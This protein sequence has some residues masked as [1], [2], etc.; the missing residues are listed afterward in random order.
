MHVSGLR[1]RIRIQ[2]NRGI[3]EGPLLYRLGKHS[4]LRSRL[5]LVDAV[6]HVVP[7]HGLSRLAEVSVVEL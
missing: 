2:H 3:F 7:I 4:Q 6:L 1:L 5:N